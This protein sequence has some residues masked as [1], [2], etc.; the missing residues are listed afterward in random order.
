M[1]VEVIVQLKSEVLDTE[2]RA[3]KETLNRLGHQDLKD[4]KVTKRYVLDLNEANKAAAETAATNIAKEFL[5]NSVSETF[6]IKV[7]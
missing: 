6:Q 5:A 3:I 4:V 2:G 1:Q 7:L